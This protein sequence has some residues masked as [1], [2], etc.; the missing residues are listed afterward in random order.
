MDDDL[1][2]LE[3]HQW[4]Y[5]F[6]FA[7]GLYGQILNLKDF[8]E[9][10]DGFLKEERLRQ[11]KIEENEGPKYIEYTADTNYGIIFPNILWT[12]TFLNTYFIAESTLNEICK[13]LRD[14]HGY[15]PRLEDMSGKGI[16]R[17]KLYLE[18]ICGLNFSS[19][20]NVWI[21][22]IDLSFIRNAL[23]HSEGFFSLTNHNLMNM[24]KNI[25]EFMFQLLMREIWPDLHNQRVLSKYN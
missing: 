19:F 8:I 10:V 23:A 2:K 6:F 13:N 21:Q 22:L 17:A 24:P 16:H 12:T 18:K 15:V 25:R 1:K 20:S 5:H 7:H 11:L 9:S 14:T 3:Q 4:V